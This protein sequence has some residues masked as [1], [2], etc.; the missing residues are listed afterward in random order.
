MK[1]NEL[2]MAEF[3]GT[4]VTKLDYIEGHLSELNGKVSK[5]IE[6][7]DCVE[8]WRKELGTIQ[9]FVVGIAI[10]IG[11]IVTFLAQFLYDVYKSKFL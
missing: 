2:T 7:I 5:N 10:G 8:E 9:R 3:K 11:S 6:R 4:V 1:Q